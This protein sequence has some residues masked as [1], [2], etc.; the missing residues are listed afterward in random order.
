M[1]EQ[2]ATGPGPYVAAIASYFAVTCRAA[3]ISPSRRPRR[4]QIAQ[5]TVALAWA[6]HELHLPNPDGLRHRP[7]LITGPAGEAVYRDRF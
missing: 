7:Q 4:F 6:C 5:L 3:A 1:P 2:A